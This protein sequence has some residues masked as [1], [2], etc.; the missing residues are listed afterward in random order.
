MNYLRTAR[1][2]CPSLEQVFEENTAT[3]PLTAKLEER[4]PSSSLSIQMACITE[5]L[6]SILEANSKTYKDPALCSV[7]MMNNGRYIVQNV[8]KDSELGSLLASRRL[9]PKTHLESL[10]IPCELRMKLVW[11]C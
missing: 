4:A 11:E 9:D 6:E 2:P 1:R 10:A 5:L 8:I 7:F 3:V